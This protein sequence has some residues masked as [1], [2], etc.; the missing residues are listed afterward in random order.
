MPDTLTQGKPM[1]PTLR[2]LPT[3]GFLSDLPRPGSVVHAPKGATPR[4]LF[5]SLALAGL[6][7]LALPAQAQLFSDSDARRAILELRGRVDEL[8]R[9]MARRIEDLQSRIDRLEQASRGQLELQNQI[10]SMRQELASLRGTLETQGNELAQTQK[11]QKEFASEIDSRVKR[12]EPIPVT[13]DGKP[14]MVDVNERRAYEAALAVFRAGDF[15]AAQL[16]FQQFQGAYPQ[17]PYGP[18]VQ[19][20]IGSSQYAQKDSKGAVSTL[21]A[22]VQRFPDHPRAAEAWLTIGNAM[23][24]LGD[25]KG[26]ADAL[27]SLTQQYPDSP[28]AATARE[29]LATLTAAPATPG[30][31]SGPARR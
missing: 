13:I 11:R 1:T 10:Q 6:I 20:W 5:R 2:S 22:F 31:G 9:D 8:Q 14:V 27:R 25:R 28:A 17:S 21:Q 16:A 19:Y 29:R 12:V 4:R 3:Q 7:S 15:R 30:T 18:G 24:D 23:L 26:A